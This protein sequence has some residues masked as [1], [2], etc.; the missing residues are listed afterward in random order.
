MGAPSLKIPSISLLVLLLLAIPSG[1]RAQGGPARSA[2]QEVEPPEVEVHAEPRPQRNWFFGGWFGLS[3]GVVDYAELAPMIGYRI[4]RRVS[5]GADIIFRY[6]KDGRFAQDVT[7]TDYGAAIFSR[8]FVYKGF[9]VE[10]Q[11]EHLSYEAVF[12]DL[13]VDRFTSDSLFAGAGLSLP[14]GGRSSFFVSVLYN[15]T[16]SPDDFPSP[17]TDPWLLRVGIAVGF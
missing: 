3:F 13:S 1:V 16:W 8:V 7:T 17:Y 15:L 11:F 4:N 14:A 6:R 2:A 5:V 10:G 12:S 9:F